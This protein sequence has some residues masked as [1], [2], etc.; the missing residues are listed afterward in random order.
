MIPVFII[1]RDVIFINTFMNMYGGTTLLPRAKKLDKCLT[2][3]QNEPA[4]AMIPDTSAQLLYN[5]FY[6]GMW[7]KP[8]KN[9]YWLNVGHLWANATEYE[10]IYFSRFSNIYYPKIY[11]KNLYIEFGI[12]LLLLQ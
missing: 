6:D 11:L 5:L 12:N 10:F 1:Q 7:Q 3:L 9:T 4:N 8:V 2:L